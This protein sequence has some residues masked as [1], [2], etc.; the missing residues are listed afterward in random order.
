MWIFISGGVGVGFSPK[1]LRLPVELLALCQVGEGDV[2]SNIF[3][4]TSHDGSVLTLTPVER[5]MY[6]D[7]DPTL[8]PYGPLP[9][10]KEGR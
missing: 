9:D 3:S 10:T 6:P 8:G 5:V 1:S 4:T 2:K 7:L